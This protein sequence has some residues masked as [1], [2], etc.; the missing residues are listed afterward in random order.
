MLSLLLYYDVT[1]VRS[2]SKT[3]A[4]SSSILRAVIICKNLMKT[5]SLY[6][7][8]PQLKYIKIRNFFAVKQMS[9]FNQIKMEMAGDEENLKYKP[10]RK[11]RYGLDSPGGSSGDGM[12]NGSSPEEVLGYQAE[13]I[14]EPTDLSISKGL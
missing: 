10:N 5:V 8:Q 2:S 3:K 7:L 11:V 13:E 1:Y 4:L 6:F 9:M 14:E 12:M